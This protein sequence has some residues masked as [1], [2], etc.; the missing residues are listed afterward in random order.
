MTHRL[1]VLSSLSLAPYVP[2]RVIPQRDWKAELWERHDRMKK[3]TN[4]YG[5][6]LKFF[7]KGAVFDDKC[8]DWCYFCLGKHANSVV[9][10]DHQVTFHPKEVQI[11]MKTLQLDRIAP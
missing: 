1:S 9:C 3:P 7:L 10:R 6:V 4:P 5:V 2:A 8:D 11:I